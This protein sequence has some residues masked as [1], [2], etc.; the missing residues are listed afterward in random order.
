MAHLD[1]PTLKSHD[2]TALKLVLRSVHFSQ[3][4]PFSSAGVHETIELLGD[5]QRS[6]I[7]ETVVDADAHC[8]EAR[9][10]IAVVKGGAVLDVVVAVQE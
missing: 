1:H 10:E 3:V 8:K 5:E 4:E 6:A 9:V 2:K 7:D